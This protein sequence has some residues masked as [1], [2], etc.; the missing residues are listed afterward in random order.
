MRSILRFCVLGSL[1]CLT[2]VAVGASPGQNRPDN[3]YWSCYSGFETD[4]VYVSGVWEARVEPSEVYAAFRKFLADKYSYTGQV[5]CSMLSP[6]LG[7]DLAKARA[8][9]LDVQQ[10]WQKKGKKVIDT[11]WTHGGSPAPGGGAPPTVMWATCRLSVPKPGQPSRRPE[12]QTYLSDA[13]PWAGASQA[14]VAAAFAEFVRT[15]YALTVGV[16]AECVGTPKESDVQQALK[17]WEDEAAKYQHEVIKTGWKFTPAKPAPAAPPPAKP[18]TPAAA[19][20]PA[21]TPAAPVAAAPPTARAPQAAGTSVVHAFCYAE[22]DVT[23]KY[24]S[25]VFDGT[26]GDYADWMPAFRQFL[27]QT[28]KYTRAVRCNKQPSQAAAQKYRDDLIASSRGMPAPDGAKVKIV[29][30]G[31]IYK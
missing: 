20:P 27:Q 18:A 8:A 6:V 15:K 26:K 23:T 22:L 10:Q 31:W 3:Y 24:Y 14:E 12:L 11:G 7:M 9:Q 16:R 13:T 30:T 5:N 29:E 4:P 19:T 1:V 17:G 2:I 21:P 28:Y 25:A